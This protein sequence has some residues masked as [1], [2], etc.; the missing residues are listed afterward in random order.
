MLKRNNYARIINGLYDEWNK[1]KK[2]TRRDEMI[3]KVLY[4]D[5]SKEMPV[6][7]RTKSI[8]IKADSIKDVRKKLIDRDYNIEFIQILDQAHLEYEKR[9]EDFI[10]ENV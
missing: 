2:K 7:E 10:L 9:S 4:Q 3:F 5:L 1:T 6:R 8:Y